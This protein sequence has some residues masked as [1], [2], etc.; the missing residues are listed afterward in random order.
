MCDAS[1]RQVW[2]IKLFTQQA[3]SAVIANTLVNAASMMFRF[4]IIFLFF[5][6]CAHR[7]CDQSGCRVRCET[8]HWVS[9]ARVLLRRQTTQRL[10]SFLSTHH[11]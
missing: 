3:W 10:I 2:F 6:P 7:F 4:V 8:F 9:P 5:G 1:R 11:A